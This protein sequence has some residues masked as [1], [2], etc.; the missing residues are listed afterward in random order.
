MRKIDFNI[1]SN[2][3]LNYIRILILGLFTILISTFFIKA[4]INNIVFLNSKTTE[5][6]SRIDDLNIYI[7]KVSKNENEIKKGIKQNK[8]KWEP[9]IKFINSLIH[10]KTFPFLHRLDVLEKLMPNEAYLKS[11]MIKYGSKNR[12]ILNVETN[13]FNTLL[14][15]YKVFGKLDLKFGKETAKAGKYLNTMSLVMKDE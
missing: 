3:R 6:Q 8:M 2:K 4:G 14:E 7:D 1:G 10:K 13:T 15:V 9:R 11:I 12:I 5:K